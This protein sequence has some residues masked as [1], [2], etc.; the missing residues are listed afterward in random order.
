M[1]PYIRSVLESRRER[2]REELADF[3]SDR[4]SAQR[5]LDRARHAVRVTRDAI[6]ELDAA[7]ADTEG[8][9]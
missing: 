4:E 9:L 7:L 3:E 1:T 2:L 6:A 8:A 5:Y